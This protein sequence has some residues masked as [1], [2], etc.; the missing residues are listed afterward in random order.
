MTT[1]MQAWPCGEIYKSQGGPG[2]GRMSDCSRPCSKIR[3]QP[4]FF[5]NSYNFE[6]PKKKKLIQ[7][8]EKYRIF[9]T[10][11]KKVQILKLIL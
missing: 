6:R 11:T 2:H 5:L 8:I 1:C 10:K 9:K 4:K 7:K 3:R